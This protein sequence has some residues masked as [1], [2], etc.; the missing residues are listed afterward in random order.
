VL[1]CDNL[2]SN[3]ATAKTAVLGYAQLSSQELADWI[4]ANVTFPNSMVD[5]IAPTVNEAA[6]EQLNALTGVDDGVPALAE[7]FRQW[8]IE[9][10]F[11]AGRPAWEDLGV[12]LR[13][14]VEA[15]EAMKGRMLNASHMMLSYPG[16][17]AGHKWVHDAAK[18][19]KIA[20]LL[21]TFM[22]RDA[23][24]Q[25]AA[26]RGVSLAEYQKLVVSRFTNENLP[27]TVLRVAH[28]GGAKLPIFHR[29]TCE[30]LVAR[31]ADVR[32]EAFLL[33]AFRQYMFGVDRRAK[34]LR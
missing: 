17:L 8:V 14:D 15:F 3:G 2:R 1:S 24:P 27:D 5:R 16:A 32:R 9:D 21:N 11:C 33:A 18:H 7:E 22:E 34:N 30:G 6:R 23:A 12:E 28:D 20:A 31:D 19:P 29:K 13:S 4:G 10:R 26:P 25:I